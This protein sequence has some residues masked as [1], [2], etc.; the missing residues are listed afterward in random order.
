MY[1]GKTRRK[2]ECN[3]YAELLKKEDFQ[4]AN[5]RDFKQLIENHKEHMEK[6]FHVESLE[7]AEVT[8][9]GKFNFDIENDVSVEDIAVLA[10]FKKPVGLEFFGLNAY[11]DDLVGE[12]IH[13]TTPEFEKQNNPS[14]DLSGVK[15]Q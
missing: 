12:E 7:I 10:T 4:M 6:E 5:V 3:M 13:L 15:F 14:F 11:L 8:E 2:G 9:D 1:K